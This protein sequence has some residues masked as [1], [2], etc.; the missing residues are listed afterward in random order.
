MQTMS[1]AKQTILAIDDTPE[2]LD[3][4]KGILVPTYAV[5]AATRGAIGLKIAA[6]QTPDLILLDI[7]MPDMDGYAV[8]A[9][10]KSNPDTAGI[11]VIF[12]TA[13]S[14]I[15]DEQ[16][17]FD[18]GAVDYIT[19]PIQPA[20]MLA[21]VASHLALADQQRACERMVQ[22]RTAELNASQQAAIYMLGEAGHFNDTDTGV[23]IWRMAAYAGL[24]AR[25][26]GWPVERAAMLELAAPMHDM[27][28][29]GISDSILKAPRKLTDEEWRTMQRHSEIGFRILSKSDAPLFVMAAEVALHHHEKWDGS[30]YPQGLAGA[31]IPESARIVALADVFDALTMKRPYKE[32]WPMDK[33]MEVV[34]QGAGKHFDPHL[35]ELFQTLGTELQRLKAIWDAREQDV[36]DG[37]PIPLLVPSV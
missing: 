3:V 5:K 25:A 1:V 2:N 13:M 6:S 15:L 7:M 36:A 26:V 21:R 32:A 30:G 8:C 28:K 24:L 22:Q 12:V 35:A 19:K 27:G 31:D 10:L 11:P 37:G 29:I 23:H 34:G 14:D 9:Q 18:A 4:I 33:A 20:I 17:G 16:R